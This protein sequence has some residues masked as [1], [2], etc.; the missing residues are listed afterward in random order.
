M[1]VQWLM[2]RT[3]SRRAGRRAAS[4]VVVVNGSYVTFTAFRSARWGE[5]MYVVVD[6]FCELFICWK[7]TQFSWFSKLL[8]MIWSMRAWSFRFEIIWQYLHVC[9]M[10]GWRPI[11][12]LFHP[13][14]DHM[15]PYV[16]CLLALLM[17]FQ[18][19]MTDQHSGILKKYIYIFLV[20]QRQLCFLGMGLY[21]SLGFLISWLNY[22][23]K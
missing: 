17:I 12:R 4:L 14:I 3:G 11:A 8:N 9:C 10:S 1:F 13:V 23:S 18:C 6:Y 16:I 5:L 20:V 2:S 15:L 7:L 19:M 22:L 21:H